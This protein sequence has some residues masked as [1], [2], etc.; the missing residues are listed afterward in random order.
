MNLGNLLSP[1]GAM[2]FAFQLFAVILGGL[3][4]CSFL[5]TLL[6]ASDVSFGELLA[7]L[8]L[9]I[10]VSFVADGIRRAH[11]KTDRSSGQVRRSDREQ[12]LSVTEPD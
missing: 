6:V 8:L 5:T 11:R 4:L 3:L 10:P 2:A 9:W 7:V 1:R 12:I